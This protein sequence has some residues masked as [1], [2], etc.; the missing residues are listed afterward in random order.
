MKT[1]VRLCLLCLLGLGGMACQQIE[2]ALLGIDS[3]FPSY[4]EVGGSNA[5]G[6][7][8]GD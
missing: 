8:G 3:D 5:D 6:P 2:D 1:F 4:E 7:G